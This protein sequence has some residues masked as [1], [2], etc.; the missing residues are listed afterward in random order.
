M[1]NG[2]F[3]LQANLKIHIST[4]H[5]KMKK[6]KCDKCEMAFRF[7]RDL[8]NHKKSHDKERQKDFGCSIC[9]DSFSTKNSLESHINRLH[10]N[11]KATFECKRCGKTFV[12]ESILKTHVRRLH[13]KVRKFRVKCQ[14][15]EKEF[16]NQIVLNSHIEKAHN[17]QNDIKYEC[18]NCSKSFSTH[19]SLEVHIK[20]VHDCE[21][22]YQCPIC[23]KVL[24]NKKYF[25][26]HELLHVKIEQFHESDT[27]PILISNLSQ[28]KQQCNICMESFSSN[29][30][31]ALH[32]KNVHSGKIYQ[33]NN[34]D[35]VFRA[36]GTL[37][38]WWK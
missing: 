1:Y 9:N 26:R 21:E 34:C 24:K 5:E 16:C 13:L 8:K 2:I 15:C 4:V 38:T 36:Q 10:E 14:L 32:M 28:R 17:E 31:I 6:Q 35:K 37:N 19:K 25:K 22:N 11:D 27:K 29:E 23:N 7:P 3:N 20:L 33:C 30:T 12:A 18:E